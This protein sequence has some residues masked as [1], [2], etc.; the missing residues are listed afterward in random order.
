MGVL[1]SDLWEA[2]GCGLMKE[3]FFIKYMFID[4]LKFS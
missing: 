2:G 3:L 4:I 1:K